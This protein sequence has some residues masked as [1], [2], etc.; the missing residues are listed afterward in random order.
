MS[1]LGYNISVTSRQGFILCFFKVKYH[2]VIEMSKN[3]FP[4]NS[5][6]ALLF[7]WCPNH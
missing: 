3:L 5:H 7:Q 2:K 6:T 1:I 4:A